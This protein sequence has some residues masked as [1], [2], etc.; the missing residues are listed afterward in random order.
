MTHARWL[1]S[2]DDRDLAAD[3]RD[4]RAVAHDSTSDA[5]DEGASLRDQRSLDRES[6]ASEVDLGAAADRAAALRDRRGSRADRIQAADDRVGAASDRALAK[7]ERRI[8]S[9]DELTSAYRRDAGTLEL[10]RDITRAKRTNQPYVVA[11]VDVDDLKETNDSLG[12]PA[13]DELLRHVVSSIRTHLRSYDLIVRVGGDEFVCGLPDL[14]M[15]EAAKRFSLVNIDLG[16]SRT[17]ISFGVTELKAHDTA[18]DL[19]ARADEVMYEERQNRRSDGI[20]L[21]SNPDHARSSP[22]TNRTF[23]LQ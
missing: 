6:G 20:D 19:I 17:A 2:A 3:D 10:T 7:L 11:F 23:G 21:R 12:H 16:V 15:A 14:T 13:G 1:V 18:E 5:R 4:R 9:F 22:T 8:S